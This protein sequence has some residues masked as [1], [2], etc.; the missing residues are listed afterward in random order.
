MS[1]VSVIIVAYSSESVI[2][3]CLASIKKYNDIGSRLEVIIVD[4]S[5]SNLLETKLGSFYACDFSLQYTHNPENGGFGQGNNIGAKIAS[6]EVL[7]FLNP[8]TIL[9][10]AVFSSLLLSV[11]A[12]FNFGGFTLVD[13]NFALNDTVGL[14]PEYSFLSIPNNILTKL[15]LRF[16][17]FTNF[18]YPWGAAL[19]IS[20][21][22]FICAGMFDERIFLCNE[23]PD[24]TRRIMKPRMKI[25]K[26]RI[27]HLEGHTT[28]VK[29]ERY[30]A[31]L[32]STKYYLNKHKKSYRVYVALTKLKVYIKLGFKRLAGRDTSNESM[33]LKLI[34]RPR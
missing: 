13:K 27:V 20:K 1:N 26:S 23:E 6:G 14:L 2:F 8:D 18:V 10:E 33:T 28:D 21:E 32:D 11:A 5:P 12:G 31:F 16:N 34:S 17:V 4:N 29:S 15:T 3:D 19:Y 24:L 30:S 9:I 7:L 25:L 22:A